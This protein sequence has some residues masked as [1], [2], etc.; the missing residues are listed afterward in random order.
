MAINL[1]GN[2]VLQKHKTI[3]SKE[4]EAHLN[5][6]IK[7][8][9]CGGIAGSIGKTSTA[10]LE[11]AKLLLQT[12]HSNSSLTIKYTGLIDCLKKLIE[13]EGFFSLWR[14]NLISVIRYF[15]NQALN[16]SLRDFFKNIFPEYH[17]KQN[18][19][20]FFLIN[21]LSGGLAGAITLMILH[22]ID[23][24][25]TRLAIDNKKNIDFNI[26]KFNG[27]YD[28]IRKLYLNENGIY[29]FYPGFLISILEI[30]LF[31]SLY[32]GGY[33]TIKGI[34]FT[35]KNT[36]FEKWASAQMN[37][38]IAGIICYPLDT[39][40]R[41]IIIQNGE[42]EKKYYNSRHCLK[43][44]YKEEGIKGY[45]KGFSANIIR[46]IGGSLVLILYD[47]LQKKA[48]FN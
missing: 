30:F 46:M 17:S 36:F 38:L 13:N 44:I 6:F 5:S 14:G 20:K 42:I 25:R 39:V 8:F 45:Y 27:T 41:R 12:Q 18:I 28:C 21:C 2:L 34:F 3:I 37:T 19:I 33:D 15:P 4:K 9:I 31:R 7:D 26:R 43:M 35:E 29:S 1:N 47:E 24:I 32:F 11:R 40:K 23:T 10:P 48:E 16:F 22:P